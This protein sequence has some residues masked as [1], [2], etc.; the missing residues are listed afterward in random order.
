MVLFAVGIIFLTRAYNN[1]SYSSYRIVQSEEKTDSVSK[2]RYTPDGVVRYSLDGAA[3]LNRKLENVWS[4]TYAMSDPRIDVCGKQV[5]LYDRLGTSIYVYDTKKQTGAFETEHPILCACVSRKG[6]VAAVLKNGEKA[7][8][9]YY[10]GTGTRIAGGESSITNP[11]YPVSLSI[12]DDGRGLAVS[13]LTVTEGNIGSLVRFYYFGRGRHDGDTQVGEAAFSGVFVPEVRYLNGNECV[14]IRD[15]GFSVCKG[16]DEP[17]ET[18]TV[19]FDEEIVSTFHDGSHVGFIFRSDRKGHRFLVKLYS[20]SGNLQSS[21]YI[22][23]SYDRVHVCGDQI[24]FSDSTYLSVYSTRGVC[25]F[26]GRLKEGNI[27]DALKIGNNRLLV[28]TDQT[29]EV[30]ELV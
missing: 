10:E 21:M 19:D 12:T 1:R 25:R 6:T 28:L 8:L 4:L 16:T 23:H 30:L 15:N 9:V 18:K 27:R 20:T 11:G 3:L 7:E 14:I 29:A 17:K 24:I 5:L 13:Y 22:D 26:Q 2:C